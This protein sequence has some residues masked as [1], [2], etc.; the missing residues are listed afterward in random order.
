MVKFSKESI[1]RMFLTF[2][3]NCVKGCPETQ[4]EVNEEKNDSGR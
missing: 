3:T 1:A 2:C 4:S